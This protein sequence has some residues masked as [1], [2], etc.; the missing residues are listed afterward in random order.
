MIHTDSSEALYIPAGCIHAVYTLHGGFLITLEFMTP[1]SVK[2]LSTLL[3]AQFDRFK[4]QW[5][6]S[7]LP[8]QFLESVELALTQNQVQVG[9][10]AWIN[11]QDRLRLWFDKDQD[12]HESTRNQYWMDRRAGWEKKVRDVWA[13]FFRSSHSRSSLSCP[14]KRMRRGQTL[15]EHFYAEHFV[16]FHAEHSTVGSKNICKGANKRRKVM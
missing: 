6:Q 4:D 10:E 7:E 8:G 14:C 5:L 12:F 11:T 2:V 15:Q 16:L 3:N 1:V 13:T 9:M